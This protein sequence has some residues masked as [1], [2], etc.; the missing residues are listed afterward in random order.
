[1]FEIAKYD[2]AIFDCDGVI[3]DS[4][5]LK[6]EAYARVVQGDPRES[7]KRFLEYHRNN[8]GVSRYYKFKYYYEQLNPSEY[9]ELKIRQALLK[10]AEISREG[11][12]EC[13]YIPGVLDF[14]RSAK[15]SG[16][17]L[18][19]V[20][21]SDESELKDVFRERGIICL[22]E[23]IF[24]SPATKEENTEKVID[25]VG[26]SK[27]GVFLG[28]SK[29]DMKAAEKF[30]IDFVFV[31]EASLWREGAAIVKTKGYMSICNFKFQGR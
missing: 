30:G 27:K 3:L 7:V 9:P 6:T 12:G 24:G 5:R 17:K 21:G 25:I 4:N 13:D 23:D 26:H 18:F 20:S 1:M 19:V 15:T 28:D 31:E 22:F 10:F 14:L 2:Y 29:S 8:G 16:V 11:L